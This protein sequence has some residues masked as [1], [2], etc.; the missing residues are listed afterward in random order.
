MNDSN[1]INA[2]VESKKQRA[3]ENTFVDKTS[4]RL[5]RRYQYFGYTVIQDIETGF[6]NAGKFVRD[7]SERE[8]G[9]KRR[10]QFSHF[11]STEDYEAALD[12]CASEL[13]KND[14][15]T[16]LSTEE[17]EAYMLRIYHEGYGNDVRGTYVPFRVFQL[18]ALWADKKHK[19]ALLNSLSHINDIANAEKISAYDE[20]RLINTQ[21]KERLETLEKEKEELVTPINPLVSPPCIY[22]RPIN[23]EYFQLKFS[24]TTLGPKTPSLKT[25]EMVNARD[26]LTK[27]KEYFEQQQ[28]IEKIECKKGIKNDRL[29]EIFAII[30]D[31]KRGGNSLFSRS[32]EQFIEDELMRISALK[33][34]SQISGKRF[35]LE[36]IRDHND[37]TPWDLVPFSIR[38]PINEMRKDKG[39]DAVVLNNNQITEIIQI[40]HH[41]GTHI[42]HDE[43]KTFISKCQE[44]RYEHIHKRLILHNCRISQALIS[45]FE[46]LGVVI[47]TIRE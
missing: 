32:K 34:T 30:Q 11:K 37:W 4:G 43:L 25:I 2:A 14:T 33:Q 38:G 46:S 26:V 45:L 18:V 7:V 17:I 8:L 41:T 13:M 10:K 3:D 35:E 21:L 20:L 44:P 15:G 47:E 1:I 31:I 28:V 39:I 9:E 6:I 5:F 22:A 12:Y 19:L 27:A 29:E 40:K 23:D 36:F 24:A 16:E 42:K